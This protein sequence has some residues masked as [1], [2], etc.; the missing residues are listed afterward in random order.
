MALELTDTTIRKLE[1]PLN[2]KIWFVI[3]IEA[4]MKHYLVIIAIDRY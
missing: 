4:I 2:H 3:C 1:L